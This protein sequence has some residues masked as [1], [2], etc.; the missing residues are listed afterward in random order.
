MIKFK[1][2]LFPL[3]LLVCILIPALK[4]QADTTYSNNHLKQDS[5]TIQNGDYL[6]IQAIPVDDNIQPD[7]KPVDNPTLGSA[8]SATYNSDSSDPYRN[9]GRTNLAQSADGADKVA[10]YNSFATNFPNTSNITASTVTANGK[11]YLSM[12][13]IPLNNLSLSIND[14]VATYFTFRNDHPEYYWL[15]NVILYNYNNAGNVTQ[16]H[17][18]TTSDYDTPQERSACDNIIKN[19]VNEYKSLV[20]ALTCKYQITKAVHDK[21]ITDI[22]YLYDSNNQPSLEPYAH[23]IIGILDGRGGVCEGYAKTLQYLLNLFG[24]PNVY[25]TGNG[26]TYPN[27]GGHAWNMV[28]ADNESFYYVDATWD[29]YTDYN[30]TISYRYFMAGSTLFN[31]EHFPDKSS[32]VGSSYLYDLPDVPTG[33]YN[34]GTPI[35]NIACTLS[36]TN[37]FYDGTEK[38]PVVTMAGLN[39]GTDFKTSYSNNINAGTATVT[40]T[41]INKYCSTIKKTYTISKA[42]LSG[43]VPTLSTSTY[44][45]DGKAKQPIVTI[46][47]LTLGKDF[48]TTYSNNINA[49]ISNITIAGIGNYSGT[50]NKTFVINK[51]NI[52]GV[53]VSGVTLNYDRKS[54]FINVT[55]P[56]GATISYSSNNIN[57]TSIN[58]SY[59]SPGEY[60]VYYK[61]SL[62]NYNDNRGY[63]TIKISRKSISAMTTTLASTSFVYN[64]KAISPSITLKDGLTVLKKGID[65]TTTYYNNILP[66]TATVKIYGIGG[67]SGTITK[68]YTIK[69]G[70]PSV[71][72]STAKKSATIKWKK[73]TGVTGYEVS[74]ST[75]SKGKYSIIKT[76]SANTASLTKSGLKSG[77]TYYFK[78]RAYKTLNGKKVYGTTVTKSIKIK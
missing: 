41:G 62:V 70:T 40:I 46:K 16:V 71:T 25:V 64:T 75:A 74:Y 39:E 22:D 38:K 27:I 52:N 68:T 18:L 53:K 37:Y 30:G 67:Y 43:L 12:F 32:N 3:I 29:D 57:F 65:Y 77:K 8:R 24:V 1:K 66:G 47:G 33:N 44:T 23:N 21:I 34:H 14:T 78:V 35:S 19:K 59:I 2:I 11:P 61:I 73:V 28:M 60:K 5:Q 42:S 20:N 49:G 10:L 26:G 69:I 50:I 7:I 6:P 55:A 13:L 56:K 36:A 45:Y 63:A 76:V 48:S 54:H 31:V 58:P 72:V 15:S 4:V 51:S 17:I 9:W